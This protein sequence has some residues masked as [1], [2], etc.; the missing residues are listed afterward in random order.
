MVT[1]EQLIGALMYID[2][3]FV[4]GLNDLDTQKIG[5]GLAIWDFGVDDESRR[6]FLPMAR[7]LRKELDA[8]NLWWEVEDAYLRTCDHLT[9]CERVRF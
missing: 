2:V 7:E 9:E 5:E 4:G 6:E 3:E 1:D 8:R